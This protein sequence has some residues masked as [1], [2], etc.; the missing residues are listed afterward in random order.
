MSKLDEIR[1]KNPGMRIMT[2]ADP[3][4][5]RYGRTHPEL[6][7]KRLFETAE[8]QIHPA[9]QGA[10][11]EAS[12]PALEALKAEKQ[13]I[14]RTVYGGMPIQIGCCAGR[15]T[16]MNAMEWHQGSELVPAVT[17]LIA[18]LAPFSAL[19]WE[20]GVCTMSSDAVEAF[21][22]GKGEVAEFYG[23]V[24]HFTPVMTDADG[25]VSIVVLPEGTN[26]KMPENARGTFDAPLLMARNKWMITHPD[27]P[28]GYHGITGKNI[29]I[30]I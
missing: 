5:R 15:N 4:F 7:L 9:A 11:Y 2:T 28:F 14:S 17:D 29:K 3:A 30:S 19:A 1:L 10:E 16:Q 24:L 13:L 27:V 20:G 6:E 22:I 25:F 8:K 12:L 18:L 26:T 23:G 21:Y